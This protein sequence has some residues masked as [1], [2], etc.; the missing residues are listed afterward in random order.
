GRGAAGVAGLRVPAGHRIVAVSVVPGGAGEAE[1]VTLAGDGSARRT[2]LDEFPAQ[3]RGGKGVRTGADHLAWCGLAT[4][5]HVPSAGGPVVLRPD[6][7][8]RGRRTAA[9]RPAVAAVTGPVVG[10]AVRR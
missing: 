7:V 5:L 9:L 3:G 2:P 4:D 10:E 1:V 8:A 6:R